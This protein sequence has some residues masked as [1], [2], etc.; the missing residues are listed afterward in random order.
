[1]TLGQ[2]LLGLGSRE[3]GNAVVFGAGGNMFSK[4]PEKGDFHKKFRTETQCSGKF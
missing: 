4:F 1:M 3:E 2:K